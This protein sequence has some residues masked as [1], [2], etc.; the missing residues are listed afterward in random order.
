[1]RDYRS[2]CFALLPAHFF[3]SDLGRFRNACIWKAG[4]TDVMVSV[5]LKY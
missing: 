3:L 2:I 1:M 5:L 4:N